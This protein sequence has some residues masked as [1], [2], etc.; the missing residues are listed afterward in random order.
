MLSFLLIFRTCAVQDLEMKR[1]DGQPAA[2]N[3]TEPCAGCAG[4]RVYIPQTFQFAKQ[5]T[6]S[7]VM[8][9]L[10]NDTSSRSALCRNVTREQGP[11]TFCMSKGAALCMLKS[12][13][14]SPMHLHFR[15][16]YLPSNPLKWASASEPYEV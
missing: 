11:G 13:I 15:P 8:R 14:I 1:G 7:T 6:V 16:A 9:A 12:G 2:H 3:E 5:H 4:L 10:G